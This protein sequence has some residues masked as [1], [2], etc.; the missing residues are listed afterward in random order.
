MDYQKILIAFIIVYVLYI[1]YYNFKEKFS[2]LLKPEEQCEI[3]CARCPIDYKCK[4]S[5]SSAY[6]YCLRPE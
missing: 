4:A 3:N 6:C 1:L 5:P 2:N